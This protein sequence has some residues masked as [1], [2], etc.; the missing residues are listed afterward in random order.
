MNR[1]WWQFNQTD[2]L[3]G[4]EFGSCTAADVAGCKAQCLA[5]PGCGGFNWPH[6]HLKA[7]TC[8]GNQG[9]FGSQ[10][11]LTLYALGPTKQIIP[12][13]PPPEH[14]LTSHP[15]SAGSDPDAKCLNGAAPTVALWL[16]NISA[17]TSWVISIGGASPGLQYLLRTIMIATYPHSS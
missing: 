9:S 7:S 4:Q 17:S 8:F 6:K 5:K 14:E 3:A 10:P 15:L 13:P 16:N 12:T 1:F 2:C 11:T